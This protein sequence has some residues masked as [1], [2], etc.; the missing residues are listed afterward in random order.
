MDGRP[1]PSASSSFTSVASLKRGGG[2]VKCCSGSIDLNFSTSPSVTSR[3][4]VL[5]LLVVFVL[6]ILAFFVDLQE[7]VE[8]RDAAGGA[9][10]VG[11]AVLA[12]GRRRRWWSD[13]T[14]PASSATRQSASRSAGTASARL[15]ARILRDARP[16]C[17][18]PKSA[19]WLRA[20]P[21]RPSCSYKCWATRER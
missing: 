12:L 20:R 4:L 6:L 10:H 9:E 16:A 13:R 8:L 5:Q 1:T 3:Q 19:G 17:A 11:R 18:A 15:P 14:P 7:A 2:S 21:A